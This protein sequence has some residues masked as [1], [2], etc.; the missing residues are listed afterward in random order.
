[1]QRVLIFPHDTLICGIC[2]DLLDS[3]HECNSCHNLF[4]EECINEYLASKEKFRRIYFCPICRS[5]KNSFSKNIKLNNILEKY[6][7]SDKKICPKCYSILEQ[8]KY[9]N[10]IN[11]CWF[12]CSLCHELFS[13]ENKFI[14]HFTKDKTHDINL[15][16]DKFNRKE[17]ISLTENKNKTEE[18]LKEHDFGKIKREKFENNLKEDNCIK[19]EKNLNEIEGYNIIYDLYFCG[20]KNGINCKCCFNKTCSPYGEMCPQCMKKNIKLHGLK[21]YYLINK[22]GRACKFNYG[23]FH[24]YSKYDVIITDKAGNF[25]RDEKICSNKNTCEACKYMTKIMNYYLPTN[26]IKKLFERDVKLKNNKKFN[27]KKNIFL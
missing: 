26:I 13:N 7:N 20:K 22:K 8:E 1:M 23:Q 18:K 16:V 15:V 25:F 9:D 17:N 21:G 19:D 6:K 5:K 4:C 2:Y 12:K 10:H 3:P 11:K 27:K 24:C 14:N